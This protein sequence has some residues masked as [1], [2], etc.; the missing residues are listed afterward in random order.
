MTADIRRQINLNEGD[1]VIVGSRSRNAIYHRQ[2]A[3]KILPELLADFTSTAKNYNELPPFVVV[4]RRTLTARV[5]AHFHVW[6]NEGIPVLKYF[7]RHD[8]GYNGS[9]LVDITIPPETAILIS[10]DE[11]YGHDLQHGFY[12][13]DMSYI[14]DQLEEDGLLP[15]EDD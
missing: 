8:S 14:Q 13:G 7:D 1:G 10:D 6:D 2:W 15:E 11:F 4:T 5:A 9:V 3:R 12:R